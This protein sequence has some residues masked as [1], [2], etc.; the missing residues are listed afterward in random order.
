MKR[1]TAR[2]AI[3]AA[4]LMLLFA[5]V[6]PSRSQTSNTPDW[7]AKP[8]SAYPDVLALIQSDGPIRV[9]AAAHD[10]ATDDPAG[11]LKGGTFKLFGTARGDLDPKNS[12]NEG[13]GGARTAYTKLPLSFVPNAGQTDT[14]VRYS[15]QSGGRSFYF[16]TREAVFSFAAKSKGLVLRLAFL[17]GSPQ[18]AITGRMPESGRVHYLIGNDPAKWHTDLPTYGEVIYRD[19]WPGIDLLFR[20]ENGQLTYEFLLR[21]GARLQDIRLAYRGAKRLSVDHDGN[22][23]IHTS[24]GSIT[25]TRP[26]TYQLI[27]GKRVQVASRFAL[28]RHAKASYGF[29]VG[30]YDHSRDLIVDPGLVYST[31]LGGS[32]DDGANAI[33]VDSAGQAYIAGWTYSPTDFPTTS[34]V[35]QRA[36]KGGEDTFVTKLN[37]SGSALVYSTYLGGTLDEP[38]WSASIA[39][40]SAGY[41][42]VAGTTLSPDFP[43]TPGAFQTS[44]KGFYNAFVTKLSRDGSNLVY[45]TYLGGSVYD[46][47]YYSDAIAVDCHGNA[48]VTGFANS[49]DFPTTPGAYQPSLKGPENAFVTKLNINGTGLVYSTLLGGSSYDSA[50]GIAIDRDGEAYVTGYTY[51]TDFPTRN[52]YQSTN[53]GG[54]NAFVTELN[55]SGTDL[56][57]STYLGGTGFDAG[58]AIAV[59][60][61]GAVY[62]AGDAGSTDFPTTPGAFQRTYGGGA[63]DVFVTKLNKTGSALVYSTYLGGTLDDYANAIAVDTAGQAYVTGATNSANFPTTPGAYDTTYNGDVVPAAFSYGDAFVTKLNSQGTALIY[64]TYLGGIGDDF[65]LGIAVDCAR[66]VYV[67][68]STNSPNFPTTPGAFD[69]TYNGAGP[70]YFYGDAFVTKLDVPVGE[71]GCDRADGDGDADEQNSGRKSKFHFHK[72]SSCPDQT[73]SEEDNVRADDDGSGPRFQSTSVTSTTYTVADTSQAVTMVGTGLHHGLPVNFTMVA[74][75]Y[76]D[77]APAVFQITLTDGYTFIGS[78][79]T[80]AVDI[81]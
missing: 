4:V 11:L 28:Q 72:K 26:V 8:A 55:S 12:Y 45:S 3:S 65:G 40:D 30:A 49:P 77:V 39:V 78:V 53:H 76:G 69:T 56:V 7:T 36:N 10:P 34:G 41:A 38:Y 2:I 13:S 35:Y 58:G 61:S 67:T 64:S 15:A 23:T 21:A 5:I 27:E 54:A 18:T 44:L 75:N 46:G 42:Y 80:G 52:P 19:L 24:L 74:V 70:P 31:Y 25:D 1:G 33:A 20:G 59:D 79:V 43:T 62:V 63:D 14:R 68:G 81:H 73:D 22:L 47:A 48:Y 37:S 17:G 9:G 32:G 16:T 57:Y 29:T 51:S 6:Y 66:K 60:W 50:T 71:A